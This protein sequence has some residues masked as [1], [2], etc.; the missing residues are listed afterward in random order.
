MTSGPVELIVARIDAARPILDALPRAVVITAPD[1]EVLAWNRRAEEL[2]GWTAT[3]VVGRN[4]NEVLVPPD[5]R[6]TAGQ[7]LEAVAG[8]GRW[9]GDFIVNDRN[10]EP[11]HVQVFE[12]A[13]RDESGEVVAVVGAADDVGARRKFEREAAELTDRLRLALEAGR[14]GTWRW[15]KATGTTTWDPAMEQLFGL[16]PGTFEGTYDAWAA[17]LPSDEVADAIAVVDLAVQTKSPYELEH[18]VVWPDGSVHWIQGRGRVTTNALGEVTGTIGCSVDITD[19][20]EAELARARLVDE[21][22]KLAERE[23]AQRERLQFLDRLNDALSISLE[24]DAVV[25]AVTQAAVPRLGDWCS[26]HLVVDD[27]PGRVEVE[28][29]HVDPERVALARRLQAQFPY[30]PDAETGVPAVIRTGETIFYPIISAAVIDA[31]DPPDEVREIVEELALQSV[32][33][34]PLQVGRRI[35]GAMQ[36]VH[37]ESGRHYTED[38]LALAEAVAGR[39][40]AVLENLRLM[41]QHREIARTLQASLL[42][43][44]LPSIPGVEIAVRYWAAGE[45]TTV[46]GDFYD[47]FPTQDGTWALVIGDVCGTGPGAAALTGVARHTIRS[48]AKHGMGPDEVVRWLNQAILETDDDRFCTAL[49]ATLEGD[50]SVAPAWRLSIT[51]GGHP[52]PVVIRADGTTKTAGAPG[53]ILGV[54]PEVRTT[55]TVETLQVGDSVV[56]YTD[57][58]TD[59]SPPSGLTAAELE[60]LVGSAATRAAGGA[61]ALATELRAAVDRILPL[62][63]RQDDIAI[64]VLTITAPPG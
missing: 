42:P 46:G 33:V 50:G 1:G 48:A 45:G 25:H 28:T 38:D 55:T 16:E 61:E 32:I 43:H 4:I 53:T 5:A 36:F 14:L 10:G 63:E 41:A 29:A 35:I 30:D 51:A 22:R 62:A 58:V 17:L 6:E 60:A 23:R 49:Y 7:I 9:E 57:G 34:V 3:E 24:R 15:D 56:L 13:V 26:I 27:D 11:L 20:K 44:A 31:A 2:Y 54:L 12:N 52:L 64:V 21:T 37:A 47:V 19:R 40:A 18:R 8:G 59:V 39:I